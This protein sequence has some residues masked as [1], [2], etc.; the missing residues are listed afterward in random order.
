M[1]FL[2][3]SSR[4]NLA[5]LAWIAISF[6]GVQF[7]PGEEKAK[8]APATAKPAEGT[9][10][11]YKNQKSANSSPERDKAIESVKPMLDAQIPK[12]AN[13]KKEETDFFILGTIELQ[14]PRAA[15]NYVIKEGLQAASEFIADFHAAPKGP[16]V[17][18][19]WRAFGRAKTMKAAEAMLAKAKNES[20]EGQ[21]AVFELSAPLKKPVSP[22]DYFVIGTA[23]T[24]PSTSSADIR[25]EVLCGVDSA[26][27]FIY[28]FIYN[29]PKDHRGEWH[30]FYRSRSEGP[31]MEYRQ[32]WRDW[33]DAQEARRAMLAEMYKVQSTV[34]C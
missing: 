6:S 21:L 33:Y 28:N 5:A 7:A 29:L 17:V 34:R 16:G 32:Q 23:D 3:L 13:N 4:L 31:A 15:L 26:A 1:S 30:V 14:K 27:A 20:I 8:P 11:H 18:R 12:P 22:D 24:N 9:P 25:F 2:P 10:E 19:D